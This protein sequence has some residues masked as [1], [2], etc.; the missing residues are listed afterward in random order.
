MANFHE[1]DDQSLRREEYNAWDATY[2]SNFEAAKFG[3]GQKRRTQTRY[4]DA[5]AELMRRRGNAR[6]AD[7]LT[8]W[9]GWIR[10]GLE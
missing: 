8:R 4:L 9:A 5:R 2:K 1:M 10:E 6:E 7:K 3:R